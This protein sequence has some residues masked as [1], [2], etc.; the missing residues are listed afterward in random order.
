MNLLSSNRLEN[1]KEGKMV[2]VNHINIGG[3]K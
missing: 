2:I 1:T 3:I